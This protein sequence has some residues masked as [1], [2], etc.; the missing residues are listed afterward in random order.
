MYRER[1]QEVTE[2]CIQLQ[3]ASSLQVINQ[4]DDV[5]YMD[6]EPGNV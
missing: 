1:E 6:F 2:I 5:E 4:Y 3:P